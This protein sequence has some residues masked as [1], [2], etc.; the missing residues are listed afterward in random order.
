M[1]GGKSYNATRLI[2]HELRHSE[3]K[4]CTNVPIM[5]DDYLAFDKRL[6]FSEEK[7]LRV[8]GEW[9]QAG[10][11]IDF[12]YVGVTVRR[13][14]ARYCHEEIEKPINLKNRLLILSTEETREF[15]LHEPGQP[16]ITATTQLWKDGPLVPDFTERCA[17]LSKGQLAGIFYVIDEVHIHFDARNWQKTGASCQYFLSQHSKMACDVLCVTQHCE[18]VDKN[19]RR[20]AQDFTEVRNFGKEPMWLG[21]RLKNTF[22]RA[23]Y[24]TE[25][26]SPNAVA[27]ETKSLSFDDTG[28]QYLY[29]TTA[30]VGIMG[31][32]D[33]RK[34]ERGGH[35]VRWVVAL[36]AIVLAMFGAGWGLLRGIG[37]VSKKA[38]GVAMPKATPKSASPQPVGIVA[39]SWLPPT[40]TQTNNK[41]ISVSVGGE[42]VYMTGRFYYKGTLTVLL[43]DGRSLNGT[44]IKSVASDGAF[45][46]NNEWF[47]AVPP[48]VVKERLASVPPMP[49]P[50]EIQMP[51]PY[52][53]EQPR[54]TLHYFGRLP[55]ERNVQMEIPYKQ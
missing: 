15:W 50:P 11:P 19:F 4:V 40:N 9:H 31:R 47:P 26:S 42:P 24:L 7:K 14:L 25:P 49:A 45:S 6:K 51:E 34:E 12:C 41:P 8:Q 13:G 46:R 53:R 2:V 55:Q 35:W 3:R 1:S 48:S 37:Y 44:E 21:V 27:V 38:V 22:R 28:I 29:D 33:D 30:G 43:S 23:T 52:E 36:T 39:S 10:R 17:R 18:K 16:V 54:S 32:L 20:D 5:L